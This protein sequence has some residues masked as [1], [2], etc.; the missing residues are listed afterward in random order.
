MLFS[1]NHWN[2]IPRPQI[3]SLLPFQ[4]QAQQWWAQNSGLNLSDTRKHSAIAVFSSVTAL[5]LAAVLAFTPKERAFIYAFELDSAGRLTFLQKVAGELEPTDKMIA[6]QL[7]E[8]IRWVRS[9]STDK[10]V[11]ANRFDRARRILLPE[12]SQRLRQYIE[13]EGRFDE[14]YLARE[15][16]VFSVLKHSKSSY[17]A[18]WTERHYDRGAITAEGQYTGIFRI[19]FAPADSSASLS[20]NP[21]GLLIADFQWSKDTI[22]VE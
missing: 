19:K 8:F 10:Q 3:K 2:K 17:Q 13:T 21:L 5:V 22:N 15:V 18:R 1:K 20:K 7:A 16:E 9:K 14:R 12:A 4:K 6:A 11:T